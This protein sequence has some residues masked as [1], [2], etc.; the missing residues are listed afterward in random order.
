MAFRFVLAASFLLSSAAHA[1][2]VVLLSLR[3]SFSNE[4]WPEAETHVGTELKAM[5]FDVVV[6]PGR[7]SGEEERRRELERATLDHDAVA[8]LSMSRAIYDGAAELWVAD[9]LTGKTSVRSV[10]P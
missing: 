7:A 10:E 9:R 8:G 5:G 6:M 4:A 3:A 2:S 1:D